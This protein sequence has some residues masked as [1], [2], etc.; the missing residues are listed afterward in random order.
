MDDT[1]TK[2]AL[3]VCEACG[4]I[5]VKNRNRQKY[6]STKDCQNIRNA[7][8]SARNKRRKKDNTDISI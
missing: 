6:C 2:K 1:D 5:G 4:K 7:R 3:F 8:K